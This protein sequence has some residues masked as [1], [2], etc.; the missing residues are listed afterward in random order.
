MTDKV[1][2]TPDKVVYTHKNV[3]MSELVKY[4]HYIVLLADEVTFNFWTNSKIT[5]SES[6]TSSLFL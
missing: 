6:E 4:M 5:S 1:V 3:Y 2:Y